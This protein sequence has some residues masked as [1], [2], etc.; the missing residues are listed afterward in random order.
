M[1]GREF[2]AIVAGGQATCDMDD[3]AA[4][5][6]SGALALPAFARDGGP[7]AGRAGS[8][9][10]TLPDR[11]GARAALASL[12]AALVTDYQLEALGADHGALAIE[13][14]FAANPVY[15]ALLAAL[16]PGQPV[17][18]S[19]DTA[20]TAYGASLLAHW[21]TPPDRPALPSAVPYA[22]GEALIAARI[23]WRQ[24]LAV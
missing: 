14:S 11:P 13:G 21:P 24:L 5:L 7:F 6:A 23:R 2:A 3:L 15:C 19:P 10:G 9:I 16:R 22:D 1:G 17:L 8:I 4:V 12:Y 18:L 20:G